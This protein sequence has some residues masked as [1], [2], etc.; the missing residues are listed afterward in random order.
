MPVESGH[1]GEGLSK[2]PDGR[3]PDVWPG[4]VEQRTKAK[5]KQAHVYELLS[6]FLFFLH[7]GKHVDNQKAHD[8]H[9]VHDPH[10]PDT[11]S[12]ASRYSQ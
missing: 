12:V 6:G 8:E 7:I 1:F 11:G 9:K 4:N 2:F 3:L 10:Y 5:H